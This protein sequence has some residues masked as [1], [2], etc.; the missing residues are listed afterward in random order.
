[1]NWLKQKKS[2]LQDY[3]F[4]RPKTR[5]CLDWLWKG[6]ITVVT[7]FIFAWGFRAFINPTANC[8]AHWL[9][10]NDSTLTLEQ[11]TAQ[12]NEAGVVHLISGGMSGV[13]QAIVKFMDIFGDFRA[14]EKSII[15][16]MYFVL[17]IPLLVLAWFKISKQFT[18]F[19]LIN[20]AL[21]SIFNEIIPD[22]WIY[23]VINI[24]DDMIARCIF[25]GL[26]TGIA[27]GAAMMINTSAGG[28]DVLSFYIAE[29]KSSGAG[30]FAF[31]I[32]AAVLLANVLFGVIGHAVNPTVNPQLSSELIRYSL[33]TFIYLFVC[34]KVIDFLNTKNKKEELQIFTSN[35]NLS[36]ILIH[37]FPH[38][39][40]T[41][42]AK[43]A[44]TG[45]RRIMIY[46]V[47]SKKEINQA[48][49]LIRKADPLAFVTVINL[50]QV[51]GRFYIRPIE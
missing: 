18:V 19:T 38:S 34:T 46:M 20:V 49:E 22:E 41:V 13:S 43:G 15:S 37:A 12:A 10:Q 2:D 3:L 31:F 23:N 47:L 28:T 17:N 16:I 25:G 5:Q 14:I 4:D 45:Q 27:S 8:V 24:Y 42:D 33:Y 39:A 30:Q 35:E 29:K 48:V 36:Q 6:F 9:M 51:Y 11:A 32:N 26:T 7:C 21:V 1:M 44:F 50:N 40:T